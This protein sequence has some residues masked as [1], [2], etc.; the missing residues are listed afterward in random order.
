MLRLLDG[1]CFMI[2][3]AQLI[4]RVKHKMKDVNF[5]L[6]RKHQQTRSLTK[7]RNPL[8]PS[9]MPHAPT[10]QIQQQKI[11]LAKV[12]Y[13]NMHKLQPFPKFPIVLEADNETLMCHNNTHG[14]F[15]WCRT[16]KNAKEDDSEEGKNVYP[17]E[18]DNWGW[19][20]QHCQNTHVMARSKGKK[21]DSTDDEECVVMDEKLV[22][23][24]KFNKRGEL[25]P[26]NVFALPSS[27]HFSISKMQ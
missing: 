11:L 21:N 18:K 23:F 26:L 24:E 4:G 27:L 5:P 17:G 22:F 6:G 12:F 13:Q 19:C 2:I 1:D 15:G 3:N 10:P 14:R 9:P 7:G 20:R 16:Q 25:L 8:L